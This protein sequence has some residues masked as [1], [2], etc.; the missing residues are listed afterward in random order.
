MAYTWFFSRVRCLTRGLR[1]ITT[2]R[3]VRVRSSGTHVPGKKSAASSWA[4]IRASTLSVFTFASAIAR[5]LR[6]FD[7]T[8]RATSGRSITAMASLFVVASNATSS[9]GSSVWAQA[10][11]SCG[12]TPMR[13]SSRHS[14]FSTTAT[15]AND[16]CTSIPIDLTPVSSPELL[17]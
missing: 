12:F 10:R 7:T 14:P 11:R 3:S 17:D 16:R 2:R 1:R 6:G 9:S 8:T 15:C 5:V 4:K 13:P